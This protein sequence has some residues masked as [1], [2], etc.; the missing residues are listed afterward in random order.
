MCFLLNL[1]LIYG[2][3]LPFSL[4]SSPHGMCKFLFEPCRMGREELWHLSGKS[5]RTMLRACEK[6]E[7]M[8]A[9]FVLCSSKH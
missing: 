4:A 9:E 7:G 6:K 8:E 3:Y 5:Q 2:I 1:F